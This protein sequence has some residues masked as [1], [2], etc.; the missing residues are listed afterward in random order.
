MAAYL[1]TPMH[2]K[3][4]DARRAQEADA[5]KGAARA[6]DE[7]VRLGQPRAQG[8]EELVRRLLEEA[9]KAPIVLPPPLTFTMQEDAKAGQ[10]VEVDRST[11]MLRPRITPAAETWQRLMYEPKETPMPTA[12]EEYQKLLQPEGRT[13]Q[14]LREDPDH[15]DTVARMCKNAAKRL[16]RTSPERRQWKDAQRHARAQAAAIRLKQLKAKRASMGTLTNNPRS[17]P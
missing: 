10:T 5:L 8:H 7:P 12:A 3:L 9:K 17:T 13:P 6:W 1:E 15:W 16:P 4:A 11:G 2:K 14:E